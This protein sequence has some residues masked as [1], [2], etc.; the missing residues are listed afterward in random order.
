MFVGKELKKRKLEY[1]CVLIR[2]FEVVRVFVCNYNINKR[3]RGG[4]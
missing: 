2:N 3:E 1:W 4:D